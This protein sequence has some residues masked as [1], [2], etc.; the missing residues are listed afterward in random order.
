MNLPFSRSRTVFLLSH[1]RLVLSLSACLLMLAGA[2][3]AE[4]WPTYRADIGR[5]GVTP[6]GAS[7]TLVLRWK[8]TSP[9][10][11]RPAW[12]MPAEEMPRTQVDNAF[13][14]VIAGGRVCF[15]SSVTDR[16]YCIEAETGKVCWTFY[17]EGPIRFAPTI[18]N[19]L[20]YLGSDD[21]F[22][23]CLRL[24]DGS[25]VW[26]FRAGPSGEKVI[27]NDRLISL[28]PVRSSVLID[29]ETA[30]FAAGVFPY[31]GVYFY[32]LDAGTGAVRWRNDTMGDRAHDLQYG[33]ISPHG[34]LLASSDILYVPSGRAMPAAFDRTTGEFLFYATPPGKT[35]GVWALLDH[36]RLIAGVDL[37]GT[38]RKT[39]YDPGQGKKSEEAFAWFPGLD[40]VLTDEASFILTRDGLHR[41]NTAKYEAAWEEGAYLKEKIEELTDALFEARVQYGRLTGEPKAKLG[42]EIDAL[43][44]EVYELG[45]QEEKLKESS[46]GWHFP[47]ADLQCLIL[48]GNHLFAGG[49]GTVLS[50]DALTGRKIWRD[51]IEGNASSL[52]F[53]GGHL[54]VSTDVG[55]VHCF[56]DV[57]SA[58]FLEVEVPDEIPAATPPA[59]PRYVDAAE[60]VVHQLGAGAKGYALV[61]NCGEGHLLDELAART[62]LQVIGLES[63]PRE[64]AAGR[65]RLAAA[66]LLGARATLES[67]EP[68]DL[69]EGFANVIV[70][71]GALRAG[72]VFEPDPAIERLLRPYGGT[73]FCFGGPNDM[74]T[75]NLTARGAPEGAGAWTQQF[76]NPQNTASS[77]DTLLHG[78]L[79]VQW[80]GGPGPQGIVE[81]HAKSAS[82]VA[83]NGRLFV[84][85]EELIR[86]YDAYNGTC[87]WERAMPGAVRVRADADGGNLTLTDDALFVAV[88]DIC[89]RLDPAT[90]EILGE[91]PLPP[92]DDGGKKRWGCISVFD[93]LLLGTRADAFRQEYDALWKELNGLDSLPQFEELSEG[94]RQAVQR[95][96]GFE[97]EYENLRANFNGL[98]EDVA[99][100]F[101]RAGIDW[102]IVTPF[103]ESEN[104]SEA[105]GSISQQQLTS[106]LVF[107]VEPLTGAVQWSYQGRR[108]A[109]ITMTAGNGTVFFAES[110]V[111][112]DDRAQAAAARA[113]A[114]QRGVYR[115]SP[116]MQEDY[117]A[118]DV[119]VVIAVDARTGA[120]KWKRPIDFTG[121]CGDCMG[122]AYHDGVVLFFG[123]LGN[124]DGWRFPEGHLRYRRVAALS[125]ETGEMLW[126]RHLNYKTR[127]LIVRD[128]LI[129]EPRACNIHTGAI[130]PREHPVSGRQVPWEFLRPG[131]TCAVSSASTNFLF[132]RTGF[133]AF[134]D[135]ERDGGVISFGA[136]RPGCLINM[137][138]AD[139]LLLWPDA[140]SGCTCSYPIRCSLALRPKPNRPEPWSIYIAHGPTTP[141]KHLAINL[142]APADRKDDAGTIWFGYPDPGTYGVR[143]DLHETIQK[144]FGY[145][146]HDFRDHPLP[147]AENP[148]LFSSGV[149]GAFRCR[150]PL[151]G[152]ADAGAA[153]RYRIRLGF[154]A[155]KSDVPGRRRFDVRLGEDFVFQGFDIAAEAGADTPIVKEFS[156]IFADGPLPV[157]LI[158]SADA[159][160][161]GSAPLLNFI[162]AIR[163][164]P[165]PTPETGGGRT[166][167]PA[168]AEALLTSAMGASPEEALAA[169]H[170]VFEAAPTDAIALRALEGMATIGSPKSLPLLARFDTHAPAI[171][172]DYEDPPQELSDAAMHVRMAVAENLAPTDPAEANRMFLQ[173]LDGADWDARDSICAAMQEA[174]LDVGAKPKSEGFITRW[175]LAAPFPWDISGPLFTA[176]HVGEP[177]VDLKATYEGRRG[178]PV[179]WRLFISEV[180]IVDLAVLLGSE[181]ENLC[182]YAYSEFV[183][184]SAR[185]VLLKIGSNDGFVCWFNGEEVGQFNGGRGCKPDQ[186]VL[187][188]MGREGT[189]RVLL[190]I[191]QMGGGWGLCARATQL[192][193]TPIPYRAP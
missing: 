82:P 26:R 65:A 193:G 14:A 132:Y 59:S 62:E 108:I 18:H 51:P 150:L 102:R 165:L 9:H 145:F 168:E 12:P 175:Y 44:D 69:P 13:H 95:L 35:G 187:E 38:P 122:G 112:D 142:G 6:E 28:W 117:R 20:V 174:G 68:A 125:A 27:G 96:Y 47:E 1:F 55:T 118:I 86:A 170:Q 147:G 121:C 37:S 10:A 188:C 43:T 97:Q 25:S 172:W 185:K 63:D 19:G 79:G 144:G 190:K 120:V 99:R 127:P 115:E 179:A 7:D 93:G 58:E 100:L 41:I 123:N 184:D 159:V 88:G 81:R 15:A 166:M 182:A 85:G 128:R 48:A 36:D 129:V 103:P 130:I 50:V 163:E 173:E 30:Y 149:L 57:T 61:L 52:A 148:W 136:V 17:A 22:V 192:D 8:Y 56:G 111:T 101:Q 21:G 39:V 113:E 42:Q 161:T 16:L 5:S 167:G 134:Y 105:Q 156:G 72:E 92:A 177:D 80:F 60:T 178:K 154:L 155:P 186:N 116:G 98:N 160:D 3:S 151:I 46:V 45:L 34:Y 67:W 83:K 143:W 84:Q 107:A 157:E 104:Y 90:G 162:E 124:H 4:D 169:Y 106:D 54:A 40:M 171:L 109:H 131:H 180:P 66:H 164:D 191:T 158:P 73:A 140:S 153:G 31:E 138:P 64:V 183:L 89:H 75:L 23:Y 49:R 139:G 87:L 91:I 77:E 94:I 74:L 137:I 133:A 152:P 189:N 135:L 126:S 29:G 33:G 53:A 176:R 70:T 32:A 78:S 181:E 110:E 24:A 76:G 119:R 2:A 114:I 141:V 71:N 11:P 146:C